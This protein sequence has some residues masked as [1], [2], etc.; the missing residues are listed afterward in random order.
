MLSNAYLLAKIGADTAENE[1][2]FAEHAVAG[3]AG[4][5]GR[6]SGRTTIVY[7]TRTRDIQLLEQAILNAH[8]CLGS[9]PLFAG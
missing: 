8:N 1:H 4:R 2:H 9:T 7:S 6:P 5:A 3:R